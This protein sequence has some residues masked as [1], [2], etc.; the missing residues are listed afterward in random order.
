MPHLTISDS[1]DDE[2]DHQKT[3]YVKK[4][5]AASVP[6]DEPFEWNEEK[7][8]REYSA[9]KDAQGCHVSF[10]I[11]PRKDTTDRALV[12]AGPGVVAK[13]GAGDLAK[14][15]TIAKAGGVMKRENFEILNIVLYFP[16]FWRQFLDGGM[17][18]GEWIMKLS[19]VCKDWRNNIPIEMAGRI[20]FSMQLSFVPPLMR[21]FGLSRNDI[22]SKL[23]PVYDRGTNKAENKK[24]FLVREVFEMFM[25]KKNDAAKAKLKLADANWR[26]R[27]A[28]SA[29]AAAGN[30][31]KKVNAI[32]AMEKIAKSDK[33]MEERAATLKKKKEDQEAISDAAWKVQCAKYDKKNALMERIRKEE[34]MDQRGSHKDSLYLAVCER[35]T[36]SPYAPFSF[37]GGSGEREQ[38]KISVD[39]VDEDFIVVEMYIVQARFKNY[40]DR[41]YMKRFGQLQRKYKKENGGSGF[42]S[43]DYAWEEIKK[44]LMEVHKIDF[45]KKKFCDIPGPSNG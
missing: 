8:M 35:A 38:N 13:T 3:N 14:A 30:G 33:K 34:G 42:G 20:L 28:D 27:K 18:S 29:A 5:P 17:K 23:L 1:S 39:Y 22:V 24:W 36:H 26:K 43:T 31:S 15:G 41:Y 25:K 37:L 21:R 7:R 40:V 11:Y 32:K 45:T 16:V 4:I 10:R 9:L 44:E 19:L 12:G 6:V 2:G